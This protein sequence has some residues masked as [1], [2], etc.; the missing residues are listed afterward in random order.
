MA[1]LGC[2]APG[3]KTPSTLRLSV[4]GGDLVRNRF[5][6]YWRWYNGVAV[7]LIFWQRQYCSVVV[8]S[9]SP[10]IVNFDLSYILSW[11][12]CSSGSDYPCH[13]GV[14][15]YICDQG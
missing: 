13:V 9:S 12:G 3:L 7:F 10:K 8:I 2:G 4:V 1:T 14:R 11:L 5:D 15:I 6:S